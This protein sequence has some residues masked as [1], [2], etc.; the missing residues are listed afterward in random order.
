MTPQKSLILQRP[1]KW[2]YIDGRSSDFT[3][4]PPSVRTRSHY[5]RRPSVTSNDLH[6]EHDGRRFGVRPRRF[7]F[8]EFTTICARHNSPSRLLPRSVAFRSV[9]HLLRRSSLRSFFAP[10]ALSLRCSVA[11]SL[12][13]SVALCSYIAPYTITLSS[14]FFSLF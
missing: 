5:N 12:R 10:V 8:C 11:P 13:L 4:P 14:I 1:S 7:P 3:H 2:R 9:S 6:L